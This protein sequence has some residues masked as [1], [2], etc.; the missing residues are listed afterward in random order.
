MNVSLGWI[1]PSNSSDAYSFA[2]VDAGFGNRF[3]GLAVKTLGQCGRSVTALPGLQSQLVGHLK[4]L[5]QRQD[6]LV[7]QVLRGERSTGII[8]KCFITS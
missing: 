2:D 1:F 3:A 7:R 6:D 5:A 8:C 4:G